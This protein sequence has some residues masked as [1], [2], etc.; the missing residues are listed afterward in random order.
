[1]LLSCVPLYFPVMAAGRFG[2]H[3]AREKPSRP[4]SLGTRKEPMGFETALED[5]Q[6]EESALLARLDQCRQAMACLGE[7]PSRNGGPKPKGGLAKPRRKLSA[8]GREAISRAAKRRWAKMRKAKT[9]RAKK[10]T[11]KPKV[12]AKVAAA[13]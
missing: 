8:A 4:L 5:L 10:K 1:M 3:L 13:A 11:A 12:A 6:A 9:A 7:S 2:T